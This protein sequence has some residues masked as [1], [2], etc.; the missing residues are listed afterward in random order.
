MADYT[1]VNLKRDVDDSAE[2]HGLAPDL[3]ARF[4]SLPLELEKSAISYQRFAPKHRLPFGHR[5]QDQE[6]LYLLVSGTAT[7]KLD[8]EIV[9][10]EQWDVIRIPPETMR[11]IE[12]GT[13]GRQ[14]HR[15]PRAPR[16]PYRPARHPPTRPTGGRTREASCSDQGPAAPSQPLIRGS[17]RTAS[18][19]PPP[20]EPATSIALRDDPG[21]SCLPAASKSPRS[22][23]A[24]RGR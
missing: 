19:T 13:I 9:E 4:A 14:L 8:D 15:Q 23:R 18:P 11:C 10:I 22:D 7:L 5:H 6:E 20:I 3:E 12:A 21:I 24:I 1:K 2:Q 16:C 17:T